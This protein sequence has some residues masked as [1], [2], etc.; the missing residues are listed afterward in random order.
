VLQLQVAAGEPAVKFNRCMIVAIFLFLGLLLPAC[1][2]L[3]P[4]NAPDPTPT[5]P[6][7]ATAEPTPLPTLTPTPLPPLA[8]LLAPAGSD[9]DLVNA[10]QTALNA[11]I[12][13]A[14]LRWQVRQRLNP[15]DLTPEL[16]LVI[17]LPPDPGVAALAAAAPQTQFLA[18]EMPGVQA[19][20]NL[21]TIGTSGA[22]PDQHGFLAGYIAAMITPE[23]RVG[24]ISVSDT[25][26]GRSARTGFLNGTVFYC[27]LCNPN[28]TPFYEYPLYVELPSTATSAEWQ[29]LADYMIDH[30]VQTVYVYPGAGDE[31]LLNYLA[32]AGIELISSG[33]PSEGLRQYWVA[34]LNIDL[35]ALVQSL[36]PELLQGNGGHDL[37]LPIAI[38]QV[39]PELL[40]PGKQ[41]LAEAA[42]QDLQA[43]Y[44]D[45]GVD[46]AT[47]ESK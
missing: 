44:I 47:G 38:T 16:R 10:W 34:S 31:V 7:S 25:V 4:T 21:T 32:Q 40:S 33:V 19:G 15:E 39:N 1:S 24:A 14:G 27:G 29:A 12:S 35:L 20:G 9:A 36:I 42:L 28:Y 22:Q 23:W 41:A 11:Q 13:A 17:A 46:P 3:S 30:Y 43:G 5:I 18:V 2:T 37:P 6:A 8:V 26:E 45:T